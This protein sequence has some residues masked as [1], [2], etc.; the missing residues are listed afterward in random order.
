M[1]AKYSFKNE[2]DVL[3]EPRMYVKL[4]SAVGNMMPHSPQ[5]IGAVPYPA[6]LNSITMNNPAFMQQQQQHFLQQQQQQQS[7]MMPIQESVAETGEGNLTVGGEPPYQCKICMKVFAIPARLQRHHR[8]HTGE[9]PFKCEYCEKT[10]SVKEN[11]NVHRRIHTKERPYKCNICDRAF[12]H[13]GKLHR[14]MRTHTGERPHKCSECGKTFVQSGQLVIHMRAHTGEKPYTC[15]YCQKG[16][17]CSK[18]LKVHI[19]THTG[20]KPYECDVCGKTFGYNHVLKMHKMSHLGEKLYKCT[21]C[22]EI[23]NSR[24]TLDRHI[25]DHGQESK[26]SRKMQVSP[27]ASTSHEDTESSG[28]NSSRSSPSWDSGDS[29]DQQPFRGSRRLSECSTGSGYSSD[30]YIAGKFESLRSGSPGYISDDSGRGASPTGDSNT[31]PRSPTA[32]P[33]ATSP[34]SLTPPHMM[35]SPMYIDNTPPRK[36][37]SQLLKPFPQMISGKSEHSK[38]HQDVVMITTPSGERVMYPIDL[39]ML[40]ALTGRD[41][42]DFK[43]AEEE[44]QRR[45]KQKTQEEQARQQEFLNSV[46]KVFKT[47]LGGREGLEP[48]GYPHVPVDTLII[49]LLKKLNLQACK[50][51]SLSSMDRIK[52]NLRMVLENIVP[53]AMINWKEK[54]IEDIVLE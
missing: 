27:P 2:S 24:K 48:L 11:L 23:F 42:G 47:I 39:Q 30:G 31:P 43:R 25:K 54:S 32:F 8:V 22:D 45:E 9:K 14:H 44:A 35:E 53:N 13:S 10:F 15:D 7:P 3:A 21:L 6:D 37:Y 4:V 16:F 49:N 26:P 12:E 1:S 28:S 51:P 5:G 41:R 46:I 50:E 36:Y 40:L 29:Q 38:V 17:T 52:V 20:E 34:G 18:Q 19:R 33:G